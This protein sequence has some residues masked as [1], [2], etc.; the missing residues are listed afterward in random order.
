M[1]SDVAYRL[2]EFIQ[3]HHVIADRQAGVITACDGA[4]LTLDDLRIAVDALER[5]AKEECP[6]GGSA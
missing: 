2:R 1:K 6:A 5:E 4:V 3:N